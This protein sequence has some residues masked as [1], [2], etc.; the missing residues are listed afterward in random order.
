MDEPLLS[1]QDELE[2]KIQLLVSET[3]GSSIFGGG[4]EYRLLKL[5][6]SIS[7]VSPN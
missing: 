2:N 4:H 7:Q 1:P 3:K 6:S 5:S